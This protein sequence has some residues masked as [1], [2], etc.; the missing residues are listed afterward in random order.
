MRA[1]V[2]FVE[3]RLPHYRVPFFEGLRTQLDARGVTLGLV[4][5]LPDKAVAQ[6]ND[7]GRLNW[8]VEIE[9]RYLGVGAATA[10]WQPA[11]SHLRDASLVIVDPG[12]RLLLN[13]LLLA[14]QRLWGP[15][16][17]LWGHGANLQSTGSVLNRVANTWGRRLAR[18]PHWWFAYTDGSARRVE[19]LGFPRDRI[20]TVNNSID[21]AL[22]RKQY[23]R[24]DGSS[25]RA[26]YA[27]LGVQ[28]RNTCL[29]LGS[30]YREKRLDYLIEAGQMIAD[31][32]PDFELVVAGAGDAAAFVRSEA[33]RRPW[34]HYV[35]PLVG[36]EKVHVAKGAQLLLMPCLVGLVVVDA[37][38]LRL[39][40]VTTSDA[41]HGPE[42]EYLQ[43]GRNGLMV[44]G[45]TSNAYASAVTRLLTDTERIRV[46]REGCDEATERY[47]L[48]QMVN[49]F[50]AGVEEAIVATTA[51]RKP[52][53]PSVLADH[54]ATGLAV[55]DRFREMTRRTH[56]G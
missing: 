5:G 28:G 14:R 27:R 3:E 43:S 11:L 29:Y 24:A 21:T 17:A 34:L 55:G 10:V 48:E 9:N 6:R 26:T 19:S 36:D 23:L 42:V 50:A 25:V 39:P 47:G 54:A 7:C 16:I 38:A 49:R 52:P 51:R 18:A 56:G 13:F 30:L 22:L 35:G 12:S 40:L 8:A 32:L 44:E 31:S 20:T 2:V 15:R 4:H 46:L 33:A 37:F 53:R 41:L 45:T 1:R